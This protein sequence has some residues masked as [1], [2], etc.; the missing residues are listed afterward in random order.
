MERVKSFLL[1]KIL[2]LILFTNLYFSGLNY[3]QKIAGGIHHSIAI[4]PDGSVIAWG[5]N[6]EG[7][8][9]NGTTTNSSTPV[10]VSGLTNVIAVAAGGYHSFALKSDGTVWA[11]GDNASYQLGDGTNTVSLIPVQVILDEDFNDFN[12]I[13]AIA[14]GSYHS[15]ALKNDGTVWCW[16]DN[17]Y[18]QIGH[19]CTAYGIYHSLPAKA[20]GLTSEPLTS[21][22]AIGAGSW[23]SLAVKNDGTAWAW[24]NNQTCELG[25]GGFNYP[26]I[27]LPV[28]VI[29]ITGVTSIAGGWD[30]SAAV[31][32][33]GNVWEWG[34]GICDP[35]QVSISNVTQIA[36]GNYHK[37]ALK[38]DGTVWT[39]GNNGCGQLGD[40]TTTDR[41]NPVQSSG[42]SGI[43]Y[44]EGGGQEFECGHSLAYKDNNT[45]WGYG[46]NNYGQLGDGTNTDRIISIQVQNFCGGALPIEIIYFDAAQ[47][48]NIVE[49]Q[50]ITA[51]EINNDYY[52]IERRSDQKDFEKIGKIKGA[53]NSTDKLS[54]IFIDKTPLIGVSY[55]RIKQV[56]FN[57]NQDYSDIIPVHYSINER[58]NL[59]PNPTAGILYLKGEDFENFKPED[60]EI[61]M[62]DL[63]GSQVKI[64]VLQNQSEMI[65]DISNIANSIYF[66]EYITKKGSTKVKVVKY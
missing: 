44:I 49:V 39:W 35:V 61:R 48:K 1:K 33:D 14:A 42:L 53:G 20:G 63:I 13:Q 27:D 38:N 52:E 37:L 18:G 16:G 62:Y 54:Y 11:W 3:A 19:G 15:L 17:W 47:N 41:A 34:Q 60:I 51:T 31:Q 30:N 66:L 8:L 55:Y 9:G 28:Q 5:R 26:A 58:I 23:H 24:G 6:L 36:C 56:D 64:S 57:G 7:Q 43:I 65:I 10:Q 50:W 2:K 59:Y 46:E 32:S 12:N 22:V 25:D 45:G 21:I 4:C 29:N 40:G